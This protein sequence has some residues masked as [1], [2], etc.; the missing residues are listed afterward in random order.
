MSAAAP[1]LH[2]ALPVAAASQPKAATEPR[3]V[4]A[5]LIGA[6]TSFL[7]LFL[8]LPVLVVVM[9]AFREGLPT[10]FRAITAPDTLAAL[11]LTLL[12][13]AVAVPLNAAFGLAAAWAVTRFDFPGKGLVVTL[14]DLPF[15]VS[16]VIAGML[17]VLLFGAHGWLG[18]FLAD[19]DI[20]VLFSPAAVV[21]AT[22]FVTFPYV[23]REL[24]PLFA[25]Q[26]T[27][28]ELAALVL[29]ASG[30]TTF[31]RVTLPKAKWGLI[32]GLV[33]ATARSLGEFGAVS[34]VSGHIRGETNTLPLH[35]EATY[36]DQRFAEAF[37][38]A[39]LLLVFAA[40]SLVVKRVVEARSAADAPHQA[41]AQSG[42]ES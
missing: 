6:A 11:R 30:L 27:D 20:R 10:F 25:A 19:H 28:E 23:A 2:K 12:A 9:E 39:T 29:G 3:W 17:F 22:V 41:P 21:I 40:V 42:G 35:I 15:A 38:I 34:V 13:T 37:A 8:G 24:I 4:R 36:D 16:P 32:H 5:V 1:T 31:V 33:L 26:G 14:I 18:P 7:L